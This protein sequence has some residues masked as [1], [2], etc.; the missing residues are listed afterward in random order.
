MQRFKSAV[1]SIEHN[2]LIAIVWIAVGFYIAGVVSAHS[3]AKTQ[4]AVHDALK[5]VP[6]A[7]AE[8]ATSK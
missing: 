4:A 2:I 8:A 5:A 1:P 6:V 3:D 7:H